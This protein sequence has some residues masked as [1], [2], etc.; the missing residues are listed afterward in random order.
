LTASLNA[1][2]DLKISTEAG[3]SFPEDLMKRMDF[4]VPYVAVQI[5][6][7]SSLS[8]RGQVGE[9]M[10]SILGVNVQTKNYAEV[11]AQCLGWAKAG[12][13][14]ALVFANV[15]VI[16]EAFDNVQLRQSLNSADLVNPDGVPLVWALRLLGHPSATRVYGPDCTK[17]I[18]QAAADNGLP[19]GFF[20]GSPQLLERLTSVVKKSYPKIQIAVAISP[21]FR[22]LT[23]DENAAFLREITDSGARFLFIGLGCPKQERWMMEHFRQIPVV[24]CAV[25]AAFDFIAGTKQQAPR[26]M[27]RCGLE[28]LFRLATEPSR[29]FVRYVKHNPRFVFQFARQLLL[30]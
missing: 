23:S 19:V 18:L 16:M 21:S 20:G 5:W 2:K 11:V 7:N 8:F 27:M 4:S 6:R 30:S 24:S 29:L 15:H 10:K 26:W 17:A 25:G 1:S 14:R 12:D 3:V 9:E 28:W 13:S 22:T